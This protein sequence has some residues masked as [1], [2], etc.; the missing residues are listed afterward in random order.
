[1]LVS[2]IVHLYFKNLTQLLVR[3]LDFSKTH[4]S[5]KN[6][7][8]TFDVLLHQSILLILKPFLQLSF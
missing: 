2:E 8:F 3:V 4:M 5:A 6:S 7:Y 1:M